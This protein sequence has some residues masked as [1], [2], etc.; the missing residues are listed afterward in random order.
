M[1]WVWV[2]IS[3]AGLDENQTASPGIGSVFILFCLLYRH[4]SLLRNDLL[5]ESHLV[6]VFDLLRRVVH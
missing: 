1:M 6:S 2:E 5:E 3:P 4:H